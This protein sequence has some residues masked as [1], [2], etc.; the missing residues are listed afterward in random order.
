VK[1]LAAKIIGAKDPVIIVGDE[2]VKS[3]AMVEAARF[4]E[5]LGCPVFQQSVGYGAHFHVSIDSQMR[6]LSFGEQRTVAHS[7]QFVAKMH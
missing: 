5:T 6:R 4:A 3:D 7:Y 1:T 2:I